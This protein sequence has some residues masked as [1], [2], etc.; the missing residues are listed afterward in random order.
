M[1]SPNTPTEPYDYDA[2]LFNKYGK[3]WLT[4]RD[5]A[6]E[7]Q[8]EEKS[9]FNAISAERFPIPTFKDKASNRRK[10]TVTAVAEYMRS[11]A[12]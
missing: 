11:T 7:L 10:A 8:I 3:A 2:Y 12:P 1:T 6:E 4:I 9:I 5:L